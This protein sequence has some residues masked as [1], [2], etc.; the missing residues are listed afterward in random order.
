MLSVA[1]W[2]G[3]SVLVLCLAIIIWEKYILPVQMTRTPVKKIMEL[4]KDRRGFEVSNII[5]EEDREYA[6]WESRYVIL[7]TER[8]VKTFIHL[9]VY[10]GTSVF[11]GDLDWMNPWEQDRVLTLVEKMIDERIGKYRETQEVESAARDDRRREDAKK[12]YENR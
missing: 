4:I 2:L 3:L 7:D 5:P 11:K 1:Q 10:H 6:G 8:R 9:D 12:I